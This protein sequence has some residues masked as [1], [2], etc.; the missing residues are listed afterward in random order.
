[1]KGILSWERRHYV[2]RLGIFLIAVTLIAGMSGC[3][4]GGPS[5][6]DLIMAADPAAGGAATDETNGSPYDGGTTISIKADPNPGYEFAGWT[7]LAGGFGDANA[8]ETTFTMPSQDVTVT[9]N[10]VAAM[11]ME[12]RDW[13]DFHAVRDNPS[14]TY[15][16][17]NDLDS[18]TA[19]YGEL[20]GPAANGGKG[21][22]P[23]G[24]Y[25]YETDE[26]IE[27]FFGGSFDGQG[28]EIRD[29]FINRPEQMGVGLFGIVGEE[30]V[31][32]DIGV[33]DVDVRG[34]VLAGGLAGASGGIITNCYA[35]GVVDGYQSIGGLLGS[36]T[37]TVGSSYSDGDVE[38]GAVP[39]A[40]VSFVGGLVGQNGG[41]IS[42][43][44]S[45]S[46]VIGSA[47]C[48]GVGGLVGYNYQGTVSN[49]YATGN[50][51]GSYSIGGLV[52]HNEDG[53]VSNCYAT[54]NVMGYDSIGGLVGDNSGTVSNSFWD[55]E[56]SGQ[57]TSD[58][59]L[60]KTTA[61]MKNITIFSDA[62]WDIIAV[63]LGVTNP[64]YIWN[65]VDGQTY[66]FLS[67][68]SVS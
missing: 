65:V 23:I 17:M 1:M 18:N 24:R 15:V 30:G 36:N 2:S 64:A 9:A 66:P 29:L 62:A 49:C 58:G 53:T 38:I 32:E 47:D 59:G 12:I 44:Y 67:W 3:G 16:L 55:T 51:T 46:N 25:D 10:F 27:P 7:A 5:G 31:V 63:G 40:T 39:E 21:W 45:T 48:D 50:A 33:V 20:A 6:Y 41:T 43:C 11:E 8:E 28:H 42:D 35:I 61:E 34:L 57:P 22:Q 14:G 54:G 4:G 68:Q 19:G 56:T 13:Y 37:G 26:F 60:G 52:G